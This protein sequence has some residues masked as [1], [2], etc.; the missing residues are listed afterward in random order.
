MAL[1]APAPDA[2]DSA[3]VSAV[4]TV[5]AEMSTVPALAVE[6][7]LTKAWLVLLS[8]VMA[9]A[10]PPTAPLPS[11]SVVTV[12]VLVDVIFKVPLVVP[13]LTVEPPP[14]WAIAEELTT[15]S[16]IAASI[17]FTADS[18]L[19]L[20]PTT[21]SE[22]IVVVVFRPDR[23]VA[24]RIV[25][26]ELRCRPCHHDRSR[27]VGCLR[28]PPPLL[29]S[30]KR[31]EWS[32]VRVVRFRTGVERDVIGRDRGVVTLIAAFVTLMAV[33]SAPLVAVVVSDA[34]TSTLPFFTSIVTSVKV[35]EVTPDT[36]KA[37]VPD[38]ALRVI[39]PPLPPNATLWLG[40]FWLE[41]LAP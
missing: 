39:V 26:R 37:S 11:T 3:V 40:S 21:G 20:V 14:T 18:P 6:P 28:W 36:F 12:V 24:A 10:A 34:S 31:P 16:A 15:D 25:N 13:A 4:L 9:P 22:S 1:L 32:V 29:R 41:V 5:V 27:S 19:S 33:G 7:P 8:T 38:A 2:S 35:T 23:D 17:G 30:S